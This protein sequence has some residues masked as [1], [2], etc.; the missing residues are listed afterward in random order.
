MNDDDRV[1]RRLEKISAQQQ[2]VSGLLEMVASISTGRG[3]VA[4]P[5][6]LLVDGTV[7]RGTVGP[8]DSMA[9]AVDNAYDRM[10]AG[11]TFEDELA[12]REMVREVLV[13]AFRKQVD[14]RET[15]HQEARAA[16]EAYDEMPTIDD[17]KPQDVDAF[18]RE[19]HS[20]LAIDIRDAQLSVAG[21]M[22]SLRVLRVELAHVAAWWPLTEEPD[23]QLHF[24]S[25]EHP[26]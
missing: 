21:S 17:V 16:L 11:I 18:L 1:I 24:S 19:T 10:I 26:V 15:A 8:A 9:D 13:G 12:G 22:I 7:V 23:L 14:V 25:G 6:G 5:I 3:G 2:S 20:P 4:F